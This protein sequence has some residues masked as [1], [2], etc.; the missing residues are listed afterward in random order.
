MVFLVIAFPPVV[1]FEEIFNCTNRNNKNQRRK[2][3]WEAVGRTNLFNALHNDQDNEV[4][5]GHFR[6]LFSKIQRNEGQPGVL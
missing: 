6:K 3:G 2:N 4:D 1:I 5:I